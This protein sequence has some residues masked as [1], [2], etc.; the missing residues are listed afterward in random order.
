MK[1]YTTEFQ[2][3][4]E[5]CRYMVSLIPQHTVTV[6]EPTK[7]VGNIVNELKLSGYDV[8]APDDYFKLDSSLR[9]DNVCMNS[10][11]SAKSAILDNAPARYLDP[12]LGMKFGYYMLLECMEKSDSV[13]ALV[14]WFTISDS[15]VRLRYIKSYG[16][17][18]ITAL[19]RKT[20][21]Y[22]RIQTC[23]L[24]LSRGYIGETTFKVYDLEP[25]IKTEEQKLQLELL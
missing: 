22:A 8:T 13:I 24:E 5:F 23:V 14:P 4:P 1:D 16:L 17:K 21:Q 19:P 3:P 2:T 10:P 9:F 11:F 7:G 15:D 25:L 12:K 20:F 6:L 18:S